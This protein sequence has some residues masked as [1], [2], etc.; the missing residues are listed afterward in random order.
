MNRQN[1]EIAVRRILKPAQLL[2]LDK[3]PSWAQVILDEMHEA[4]IESLSSSPFDEY[5]AQR[6]VR[7]KFSAGDPWAA[8]DMFILWA[9]EY[10][11]EPLMLF[12]V[13]YHYESGNML[14]LIA[15]RLGIELDERE[16]QHEA[17]AMLLDSIVC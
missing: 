17:L 9:P 4:H 11:V 13:G 15:E 8:E 7:A 2:L 16:P 14:E 5:Y 12:E 3:E 1:F 6:A 10:A